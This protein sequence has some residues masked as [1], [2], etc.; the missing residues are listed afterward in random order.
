MNTGGGVTSRCA[1]GVESIFGTAVAVSEILPFTSESISRAIQQ[2][3]SQYQDGNVGRRGLKN[4]VVSILGGLECELVWDEETG[5]P[6]G[7]ERLLR[8]FLGASARDAVN[9]LNQYKTAN[10]V[11]D[12][13]TICFNKQVSNWEVVSAKFNTLTINGESGGKIL[14]STEI[15]GYDLLR[16]G[17]A[18]ITNAIAAVTGL[19]NTN[20]PEN[21]SFDDMVFRIGDQANALA[22]GDQYKIDSFELVGNNNLMEPQF[23][24][25][26]SVHTDSLKTLEP[27]RNGQREVNLAITSPRYESDQFFTWLNAGT[28]LQVDI[29]FTSGSYEFN[30]LL[31]NIKIIGDPQAQIA[32]A[33]LI[34]PEVNIM[35]LR[36]AA[37]HAHMTYQDSDLIADEI[38]IEAKSGRTSA[39]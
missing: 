18:G 32:G 14:L 28:P 8:G 31:P 4:S 34:K 20:Q 25:V 27:V 23:S 16:T 29:K 12:H 15:I 22:A 30:I 9:G 37:K 3:E 7:L 33:E 17:D 35:A 19:S 1:L 26:D 11:D 24:S 39:A 38:G 10:A 6:I 21:L 13:Y 36:L 2:L 5:D